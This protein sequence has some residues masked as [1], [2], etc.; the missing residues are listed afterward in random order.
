MKNTLDSGVDVKYWANHHYK[1][2][3]SFWETI[4]ER[5]FTSYAHYRKAVKAAQYS[6][7]LIN[8]KINETRKPKPRDIARGA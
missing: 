1:D 8:E 6:K 7:E 5:K 3:M 4:K 2:V